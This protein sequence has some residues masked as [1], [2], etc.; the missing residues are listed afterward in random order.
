MSINKLLQ[1]IIHHPSFNIVGRARSPTKDGVVM[2][3]HSL[4]HKHPSGTCHPS[5]IIPLLQ[6]Y[7]G[8]MDRSDTQILSIFQLFEKSRQMSTLNILKNWAPESHTRP[9]DLLGA[10][11]NFDP[12]TMFRTCTSFPQRRDSHC[13]NLG[14]EE[15]RSD[16]YD[17]NFVLPLLAALMVSD[18]PITNLQW[19]ELCRTNVLSLA[20]ASLSSK[21]STMRQ[22]GYASLVTAYARFSVDATINAQLN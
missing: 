17:P 4:F 3:L 15:S 8:T 7:R 1:S 14:P 9:M 18:E 21:H 11:C 13:V 19:V 20:V 5:H 6:I 12:V 16:I 22:L 10:V 2:L